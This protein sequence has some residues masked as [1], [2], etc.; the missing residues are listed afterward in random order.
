METNG[1]TIDEAFLDE[2]FASGLDVLSINLDAFDEG[3]NASFGSVYELVKR[4][5]ERRGA[6]ARPFLVLQRVN[7]AVPNQDAKIQR[8][9]AL[10]YDVADAFVIRP[11]NTYRGAFPDKRVINF[12][13]LERSGCRKVLASALVL[14]SGEVVMCEQCFDGGEP[15][16]HEVLGASGESLFLR[17]LQFHQ[18]RGEPGAFCAPCGQWYQRDVAWT[19]PGTNQ[20]WFR[21]A[22]ASSARRVAGE[23]LARHGGALAR[24]D[25][26]RIIA[27]SGD[28]GDEM[29]RAYVEALGGERP[30]CL[31][32]ACG[33]IGAER[34]AP[35]G[36]V[37]P[38]SCTVFDEKLY[39]TDPGA[40]RVAVFS[41]DGTFERSFGPIA[42]YEERNHELPD[43][44]ALD[45]EIL[46]A[47]AAR[48]S[49][50]APDGR[51][52]GTLPPDLNGASVFSIAAG[53][54]GQ[55]WVSTERGHVVLV[56]VASGDV[57]RT[58]H[59]PGW[60]KVIVSAS[61]ES[62]ELFVANVNRHELLVYNLDGE[63]RRR[64]GREE[65]GRLDWPVR[66][67][68]WL[69]GY[70][71]S[72]AGGKEILILS[73]AFECLG[74]VAAPDWTG[75]VAAAG[76]RL[77]VITRG[78]EAACRVWQREPVRA[79]LGAR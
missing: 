21:T 41:L 75:A 77:F 27:R 26:P 4:L 50:F 48:V 52:L 54:P 64:I 42:K 59:D 35:G 22:I 10:W 60:L 29:Q 43:V 71:V 76:D 57:V 56:D 69:D 23:V 20:S 79:T 2:V 68:R 62:G 58:L 34:S 40:Q 31:P 32:A 55:L 13:P 36:L 6:A 1:T 16:G 5:I 61:T 33:R 45:G 39:V 7:M 67:T 46:I 11:F 51:L 25:I 18:N 14:S 66:A 47:D 38:A 65:L 12:A 24:T 70:A 8:D 72:N 9:F 63:L 3:G 74:A 53:G 37:H 49:R 78:N 28:Y 44:A 19:M 73:C 30:A 17:S 15:G